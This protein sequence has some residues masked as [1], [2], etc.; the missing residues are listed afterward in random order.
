MPLFSVKHTLILIIAIVIACLGVYYNALSVPFY[1]DDNSSISRNPNFSDATTYSS[2]FQVYGMRIVGYITLWWDYQASGL[3]VRRYHY[4]NNAIHALMSVSIFVF[5]YL[6]QIAAY[7]TTAAFNAEAN[8]LD[9]RKILWV[10]GVVALLFAVHPL[11]AQ[12]VTYIVQRLASLT[13]LFYV[14]CMSSYLGF[15]LTQ[16]LFNKFILSVLTLVFAGLAVFSKQNAVTL[17]FAIVLLELIFFHRIRLKYL[18]VLVG[19]SLLTAIIS[20]GVAPELFQQILA[21]VD[22]LTRE[23]KDVTRWDYFSVQLPIIWMYISKIVY[24]FPL[25]LEYSFTLESFSGI[26]R[27]IAGAAHLGLI[28]IAILLTKRSPLISFGILFYYLS[29]S[30]ESGVIPITDL[31]F[32]HRTYLPNVGLLIALVSLIV[33]GLNKLPKNRRVIVAICLT[34]LAAVALS[35][36]TIM[37]NQQ[38]QSPQIFFTHQLIYNPT[39]ARTLHSLAEIMVSDDKHDMALQYLNRLYEVSD[40]KIDGIMLNTHLTILINERKYN[41]ALVLGERLLAKPLH[42]SARTVILSNMGIIHVNMKRYATAR[43]FFDK[44]NKYGS[45]QVNALTAYGYSLYVLEDL[46]LAKRVVSTILRIQPNESKAKQLLLM[47][48]AKEDNG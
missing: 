3:D 42:P 28:G 7:R 24:P 33:L 27:L 31:A 46:T 21:A 45:M 39:H 17:P 20:Y 19:V 5:V 14:L 36:L 43:L 12:A 15:R 38:W 6:L 34:M 23:N 10:S 30:I 9:H 2:L 16:P 40:G 32:E 1:L 26:Q 22:Q 35:F 25:L 47:I 41:D 29:H 8:N 48:Q 4:V 44:A 37:R 18:G 13:A 11:N